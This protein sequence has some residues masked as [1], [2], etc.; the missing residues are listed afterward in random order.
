MEKIKLGQIVTAVGIKGEVKVYPYTDIPERFEEID[1][2]MIESK[3][4]KIN[5]VRYMKNMV[6]L[7]L[8]GVDDRNAAE[9]LR[10]KNLYI[11]RKDMWEM[12]EDT[13]LVKDLLG[14]TVMD[15]EGNRIG[16]LVDVI[17]NS[18]QDLYEI[19]REDGKKFLL[20]AVG[21]FVQTVNLNKRIM[22]VRL[23]E[24]LVEL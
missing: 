22:I 9:A 8:E 11:D 3:T 17:Q 4:A 6:I 16:K 13:Y 7:R 18:A 20:P 14:M 2:L 5:G 12:P 21:E 1:S 23:I 24:G 10:G 19:E 15:P